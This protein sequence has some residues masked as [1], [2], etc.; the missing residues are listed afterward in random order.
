MKSKRSFRLGFFLA[1]TLGSTGCSDSLGEEQTPIELNPSSLTEAQLSLQRIDK[2][3]ESNPV[4]ALEAKQQLRPRLDEINHLIARVEMAP[5]HHVEFYDSGGGG[6]LIMERGPA[7]NGH[8]LRDED[9]AGH[10]AVELY[11]RLTGGSTPPEALVRAESLSEAHDGS[12]IMP[13]RD[14]MVANPES[15]EGFA[16]DVTQSWTGADGQQW[17]DAACFKAGEF[18]GCFP[19]S[20][21]H[22]WAHASAKTSFF[23]LGPY[24]GSVRLQASYNGGAW[25]SWVFFAGESVQYWQRSASYWACPWYEACG[26]QEYYIRQH[27]WDVLDADGDGYHFSHAFRSNC[28]WISCDNAP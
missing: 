24:R 5:E 20:T 2:L 8:I 27:R 25:G 16:P 11:R 10:S 14:E 4:A 7:E 28:S 22:G 21:G 9:V 18:F 15:S 13:A 12:H 23:R 1:A 6:L 3:Y 26:V 19:N 17:R